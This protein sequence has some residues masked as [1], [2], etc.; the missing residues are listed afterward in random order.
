[1]GMLASLYWRT[2]V[3]GVGV[4]VLVPV[5][6][7]SARS[8]PRVRSR[9]QIVRFPRTYQAAGVSVR[10]WLMLTQCAGSLTGG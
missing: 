9:V 5:H 10:A 2:G 8:L 7:Q 1:M 6:R 3:Q 4:A